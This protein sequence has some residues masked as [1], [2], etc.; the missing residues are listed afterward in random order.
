VLHKILC[1]FTT[2]KQ[3]NKKELELGELTKGDT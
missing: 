3:R 1:A 2:N